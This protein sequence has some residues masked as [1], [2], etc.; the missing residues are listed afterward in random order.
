MSIHILLAG[1][2]HLRSHGTRQGTAGRVG[3]LR[4]RAGG[5]RR[6]CRAVPAPAAPGYPPGGPALVDALHK[7][8]ERESLKTACLKSRFNIIGPFLPSK[9]TWDDPWSRLEPSPGLLELC[10]AAKTGA[11]AT[12]ASALS[13]AAGACKRKEV[14]VNQTSYPL[15]G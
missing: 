8:A 2:V 12:S 13:I 3:R 5:T 6:G 11:F 7:E 9:R 1:H 15:H 14:N 10:S 4:P